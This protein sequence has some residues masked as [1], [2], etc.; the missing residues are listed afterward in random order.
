MRYLRTPRRPADAL[1]ALAA[2]ARA[3][4]PAA[5][6]PPCSLKHPPF[7]HT[8]PT[9]VTTIGQAYSCIFAH[10]YAAATL[11]DRVLLAAAFAGL[12][13]QLDR[14]GL[15]QPDATMP[16]LTGNHDSDWA[17]FAAVY[18]R[19]I[20][21][22]PAGNRQQAAEATMTAMIKVLDRKSVV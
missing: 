3:S 15:D 8:R 19:I 7:P 2:A 18:Q 1:A 20:S 5:G 17:A 22:L 21:K 14:L 10:Y 4:G 6:P 12:T 13:Q 11:D 9:T 16:A